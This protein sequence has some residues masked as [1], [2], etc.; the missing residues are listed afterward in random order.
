MNTADY[1][2]WFCQL[3]GHAGPRPVESIRQVLDCSAEAF[4]LLA[5]LVARHHGKVRVALHAV[6]KDQ[7]YID[8]D[9]RG[10]PIRGVRDGD[11]LP[12]IAIAPD[13]PLPELALTLEPT[14]LGLSV[15]T[16]ASWRERTSAL[17][18]RHS[19]AG[20]AFLESLLR[21]ADIR[22]SRLE[23]NDPTWIPPETESPT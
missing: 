12:A 9:G 22:A 18:H 3:T 19:P 17:H 8:R 13:D 14:A 20:L 16:G 2:S 15:R 1:A 7:D 21:V 5:Y 23:T 6:P 4:D 10:L 11:Q